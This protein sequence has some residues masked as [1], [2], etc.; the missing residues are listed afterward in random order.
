MVCTAT[1]RSVVMCV[2]ANKAMRTMEATNVQ[3]TNY[4]QV[5]YCSVCV[6]CV[7]CLCTCVCVCI[8]CV[9]VSHCISSEACLLHFSYE[10][11][12]PRS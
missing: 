7:D 1:I 12:A 3:V 4:S 11:L 2:I 5:C 6:W 8:L 10:I 9:T